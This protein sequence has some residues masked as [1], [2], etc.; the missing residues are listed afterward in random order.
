MFEI[1]IA[2][3]NAAFDNDNHGNLEIARILSLVIDRL[4][5]EEP[6]L[7]YEYTLRDDNGNTTGTC[8]RWYE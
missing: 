6:G 2:T 4:I 5:N 8:K 7:T 3:I 1:R